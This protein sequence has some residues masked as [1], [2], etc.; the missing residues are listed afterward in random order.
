VSRV[1]S[2][3]G[4]LR[5]ALGKNDSSLISTETLQALST[6]LSNWGALVKSLG[7][8]AGDDDDDDASSRHHVHLP[9]HKLGHRASSKV[10]KEQQAAAVAK[11]A[12]ASRAA[13]D[14]AD[15]VDVTADDPTQQAEHSAKEGG[16]KVRRRCVRV[17]RAA[18]DAMSQCM[19]FVLPVCMPGYQCMRVACPATPMHAHVDIEEH[20][21]KP[22]THLPS[23]ALLGR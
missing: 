4:R 3:D 7:S 17:F 5:D 16:R 2:T 19:T 21:L 12:Q 20:P 10:A 18:S 15:A 1:L 8:G 23:G 6:T 9:L 13:E 14:G 22:W 11:A